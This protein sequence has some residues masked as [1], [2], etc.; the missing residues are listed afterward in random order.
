MADDTETKND[1]GLSRRSILAT[2]VAAAATPVLAASPPK[3][4]APY[5]ASCVQVR[6]VPVVSGGTFDPAALKENVDGHIAAINKGA[7]EIGARHYVFPGS[8][9][10]SGAGGTVENANQA[11]ITIPGPE[12]DRIGKVA[13]ATK[14][15]VALQPTEKIA[16]FPGRNFLST[17]VI[18]P[19]GDV[20]VNYRKHYDFGTKTCPRDI[21]DQWL[22]KFG[23][24][25]LFPVA[26]TEIGRI[27][28]TVAMDINW[29]E[30]IRSLAF[31]GAEIVVNPMGF[32]LAAPDRGYTVRDPESYPIDLRS[33][34]RRVRAYENL[35]YILSANNGPSGTRPPAKVLPSEIVDYR[36]RALVTGP[37]VSDERFV[38]AEIDIE[39]LRKARTTPEHLNGL[40]Q[41]QVE[42]HRHGYNKARFAR[43]NAFAKTPIKNVD[44]QKV[45][46]FQAEIDDLVRRGVLKAPAV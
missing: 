21:L 18:G 44:E 19:S 6:T 43:M 38:T 23:P 4:I 37:D 30:M 13:Q 1:N 36:G 41:V 16:A 11:A 5:K 34:V 27:G 14:S 42:I 12:T 22:A 33:M 45:A 40:A 20:L 32:P 26:D 10:Q 46:L 39:A 15:Y 3:P 9:L 7:G 17:V 28:C 24:D 8:S 35:V 2:T 31:N 25:S 29:P